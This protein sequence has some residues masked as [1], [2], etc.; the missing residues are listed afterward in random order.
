MDVSRKTEPHNT[1][2]AL[3]TL[4]TLYII[5]AS[6]RVILTRYHNND[7]IRSQFFSQLLIL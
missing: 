5:I 1:T 6:L 2:S 7:S 3:Y 4:Y